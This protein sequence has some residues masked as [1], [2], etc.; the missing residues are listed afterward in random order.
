VAA[1][2]ATGVL[3]L[4]RT[5]FPAMKNLGSGIKQWFGRAGI[6]AVLLAA[7]V[8]ILVCVYLGISALQAEKSL[9]AV[10]LVTAVVDRFIQQEK[11]WPTSWDELR[12]INAV[13]VPSMYSWPDDSEAVH[14]L[15]VINF[16]VDLTK[17]AA[18]TAEDFDA[19][20]PIGSCFPYKDFRYV[21][22]LI[23]NA[24]ATADS[25]H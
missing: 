14:E 16:D 2:F 21:D 13:D 7:G 19:I 24:K 20:R 11:R 8:G 17:I 4:N 25:R 23:K 12:A 15:V 22:S 9:H 10:N 18:Q 1:H 6:V 5:Q 3:Q